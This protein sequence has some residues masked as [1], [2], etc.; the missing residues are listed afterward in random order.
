M[1]SAH[2]QLLI[3][4]AQFSEDE[5]Q[6]ICAQGPHV[7]ATGL[8]A[9]SALD[10]AQRTQI[11]VVATK[12]FEVFT[13][14]Q[15]DLF[16][17]L[18]L[19]ANFGVGYDN[20][21][22]AAANARGITVTN[23]PDVLDDDVADLAVALMLASARNI[24]QGDAHVR[25][26][27]WSS[28]QKFGL[29]RKMSGAKV[30]IAGLGRIGRAI[31]QRLVGFDMEIHYSSRGPKDTPGWT[32]HADPVALAR[33]VDWLVVA[34]VGGAETQGYISAQVLKALGPEGM[35]I[36]IARGT[37]VD[38]AALLDALEGKEIA[39]AGLDVYLNEPRIDP[40]F[41]ALDN[42]VLQPHQASGTVQ[43]R[44]AMSELQCANIAAQLSGGVLLTPV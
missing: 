36:N 6:R 9:Q 33:E 38:E 39:G 30:G 10:A 26:G 22:L 3:A 11:T 17:N 34:V 14:E 31:A 1:T 12:V 15:M 7:I 42:V 29:N 19:I 24:I 28:G 43:T 20:I 44:R 2:P 37:C 16:P 5:H 18:K 23:T 27:T 41:F 4:T 13:P 32:Y 21:D 40:R 35:L 8:A 25:S